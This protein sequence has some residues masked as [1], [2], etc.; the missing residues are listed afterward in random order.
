MPNPTVAII[1]VGEM[2]SAVGERLAANGVRVV[3]CLKGRGADSA[4][5]A[6]AAGFEVLPDDAALVRAAD[7]VLSILP[8]DRAIELA[9]RLAKA[10]RAQKRYP[11]YVDCNAVAP[12]TAAKI[13]GIVTRAGA[14]FVDGGIIGPPPRPDSA[15]T[16]IFVS[17]DDAPQVQALSRFGVDFRVVAGGA[18]AASALKMCYASMTKGGTALA[19]QAF[20]AAQ[21]LGVADALDAELALSHPDM[22]TQANRHAKSVGG[23]AYRW[24]GEME[25]IAATFGAVGLWPRLF[26]EIAD[27]Y[28]RVEAS[29]VGRGAPAQDM[30][31]VAT[32]L[33]QV[34]RPRK[35]RATPNKRRRT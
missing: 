10:I 32:A 3:T 15:R 29:A 16:R 14:R 17:G 22:L 7:I 25:E 9:R 34:K 30:T 31:A 18:V 26:G 11:I 2:G 27:I 8:P 21:A 4:R 13:G 35:R 33:L 1:G 6:A 20:T 19:L 5:R 23:K 24:I 12:A 28:R